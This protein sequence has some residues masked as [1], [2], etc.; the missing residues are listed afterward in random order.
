ML[1]SILFRSTTSAWDRN[2]V[3]LVNFLSNMTADVMNV[4]FF[5]LWGTYN[6]CLGTLLYL[7]QLMPGKG[8][9]FHDKEDQSQHQIRKTLFQ[10]NRAKCSNMYWSKT[11]LDRIMH[12][13]LLLGRHVSLILFFQH[14]LADRM[15]WMWPLGI[16]TREG[17]VQLLIHSALGWIKHSSEITVSSFSPYPCLCGLYTVG[18]PSNE[19]KTGSP[20]FLSR[21]VSLCLSSTA[22]FS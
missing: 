7:Q 8:L 13:F 6:S 5:H 18:H 17:Q 1:L 10:Q 14:S 15:V 19:V 3:N 9:K 2:F 21:L 16:P 12:S 11:S 20:T 4:P 22:C